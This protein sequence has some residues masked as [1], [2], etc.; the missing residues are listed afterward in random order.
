MHLEKKKEKR[1]AEAKRIQFYF[2]P[3]NTIIAL[4]HVELKHI[5]T[6]PA[7]LIPL[8]ACYL[9]FFEPYVFAFSKAHFKKS[10]KQKKK[11][12]LN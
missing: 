8:S 12:S 1:R 7:S 3:C 6:V 11:A 2:M 5:Q 4:A 9:H 10:N